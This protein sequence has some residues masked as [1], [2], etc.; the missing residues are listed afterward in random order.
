MGNDLSYV[1]DGAVEVPTEGEE[2]EAAGEEAV[3]KVEEE[4]GEEKEKEEESEEVIE[5]VVE[6]LEGESD[7]MGKSPEV[8]ADVEVAV[9]EVGIEEDETVVEVDADGDL[10]QPVKLEE[11]MEVEQ[12]P[13]ESP[14]YEGQVVIGRIKWA[15]PHGSKVL[16]EGSEYEGY[17]CGISW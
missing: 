17:V 5:S 1:D 8:E 7:E 9:G 4:K 16:I 2:V 15:G 13:V 3:E 11:E 10:V 14:F 12:V 6:E